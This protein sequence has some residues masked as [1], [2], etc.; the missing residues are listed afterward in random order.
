MGCEK[1]HVKFE[2]RCGSP[3]A[4]SSTCCG[5][6]PSCWIA[7]KGYVKPI[8]DTDRLNWMIKHSAMV[9]FESKKVVWCEVK[10]SNKV[11]GYAAAT[12]REAIDMAMEE[13]K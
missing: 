12:A 7:G 8:T 1:E 13:F 11:R 3:H 4:G 10:K 6:D 5:C 9:S 2:E